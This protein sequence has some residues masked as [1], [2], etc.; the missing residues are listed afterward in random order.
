MDPIEGEFYRYVIYLSYIGESAKQVLIFY[1]SVHSL[2]TKITISLRIPQVCIS[3]AMIFFHKFSLINYVFSS[4]EDK[5]ETALAC[6]FLSTKVNNYLISLTR[7]VPVYLQVISSIGITDVSMKEKTL[8][9]IS[10]LS[11]RVMEKEFAVL[12]TIGFD[13][14]VDLPY[15]YL[16][17]M[18]IYF[19]EHINNDKHIKIIYNFLNDSF[20]LPV[21]LYYSPLK[22]SLACIYLFSYHFK[23]NLPD[24]NDGKKWYKILDD[25]IELNE[26]TEIGSII[27]NIYV[28]LKN[29][30]KVNVEDKTYMNE[31]KI[32]F[33]G[34]KLEKN[35]CSSME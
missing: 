10:E 19:N 3:T 35:I 14:N 4:E 7:L 25:T 24:M 6:L 21:S 20:K 26:I 23:T 9:T 1:D 2:I 33:L 8:E 15:V 17:K 32:N 27:N 28:F 16:E 22:V 11:E 12:K 34:K 29:S 13:L 5:E 30:K 18:K 31:I